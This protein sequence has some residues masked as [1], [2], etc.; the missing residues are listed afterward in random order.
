MLYVMWQLLTAQLWPRGRPHNLKNNF[1]KKYFLK[2]KK[3]EKK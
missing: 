3:S 2:L 1:K